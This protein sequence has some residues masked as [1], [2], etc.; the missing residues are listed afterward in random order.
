MDESEFP[1]LYRP[2]FERDSC[3]FGLIANI[4]DAPSHWLVNTAIRALQRLTHRGAIAADGKKSTVEYA[5]RLNT[6]S[7][8]PVNEFFSQQSGPYGFTVT[9]AF[10]FQV[11]PVSTERPPPVPPQFNTAAI[12]WWSLKMRAWS[13]LQERRD[14]LISADI[15]VFLL[16]PDE[17]ELEIGQLSPSRIEWMLPVV[18][19][20][21][22]I[23]RP[24]LR[25]PPEDD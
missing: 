17:P 18:T 10:R 25:E 21:A 7:F 16:L 14:G 24:P 22:I 12:A 6:D 15:Q 5:R 3:G 13:W 2:E 1:G 8:R 23:E 9:P 19:R 11:A 20:I 4:D